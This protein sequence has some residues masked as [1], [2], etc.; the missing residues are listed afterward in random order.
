MPAMLKTKLAQRSAYALFAVGTFLMFVYA[1]F[2]T[3]ALAGRI[4][5]EVARQSKGQVQLKVGHA[6]LWRGTGIALEDVHVIRPGAQ[7]LSF[8]ALRVRLRLLPLLLLRRSVTVQVPAGRGLFVS[9][10]TKHGDGLDVH[11][12][13]SQLDF[14][15]MPMLSRSLGITAA[16]VLDLEG[17]LS[18]VP[19]LQ[20]TQGHLNITMDHVAMGPGSVYGL[21]LPRLDL[22]KLEVAL[23][24]QD[25]HAKIGQFKQTG[26]TV[27]LMAQGGVELATP[28]ARSTLDVCSKVRL[29]PVFLDKNPKLRS[30]MQLAEVQLRRDPDG[31]LNAPLV[32]T[33]GSP[34]LR[35]G[36]CPKR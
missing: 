18:A 12:E 10:L 15:T 23:K 25:G 1:G 3:D 36:L 13:A 8:D 16:G 2:P 30:V 21:A 26:G 32:G 20:H 28:V 7:P 34:Q 11:L 9:T 19:D 14:A 27:N 33:L 24:V 31:F 29:D 5:S 6:S 35:P 4:V 22:G 17:D